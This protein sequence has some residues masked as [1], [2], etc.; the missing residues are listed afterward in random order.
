MISLDTLLLA[1]RCFFC[2]GLVIF[3]NSML[4]SPQLLL[5]PH[6]QAQLVISERARSSVNPDPIT[7]GDSIMPFITFSPQFHRRRPSHHPQHWMKFLLLIRKHLHIQCAFILELDGRRRWPIEY[8]FVFIT[9]NVCREF[10]VCLPNSLTPPLIVT[11]IITRGMGVDYQRM[12]H[13]CPIQRS[14]PYLAG[15]RFNNNIIINFR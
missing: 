15:D 6:P 5:L 2:S 8:L 9:P 13:W 12:W 4:W 1:S 3:S 14:S 11:I 7:R 10:H